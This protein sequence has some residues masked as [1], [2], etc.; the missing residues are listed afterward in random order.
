MEVE[1]M[2]RLLRI[3]EVSS[4]TGED[5]MTIYGRIRRGEIKGIKIGKRNIRVSESALREWL[6][7]DEGRQVPAKDT[8]K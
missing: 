2:E 8:G 6:N 4:I 1:A 3:K 5:P 7:I